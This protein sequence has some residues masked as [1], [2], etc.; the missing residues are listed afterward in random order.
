M[1]TAI[2][3]ILVLSF[4][5]FIHELGHFL[6]AKMVGIR[7]ER[8]SIGFP[9][10]MFGRKIGETDYCIS[11][12]PLGGYVKMSGMVDES[13]DATISG[14][15]WEFMSKSVFQRFLVI[16]AGPAMN[17]LLAVV[18]FAA[19]T[20]S[21]GERHPA[22]A[23]VQSVSENMPAALAGVQAGDR[24]LA[25][26][27]TPVATTT[28]VKI[29]IEQAGANTSIAMTL[30][31]GAD[32]V[33]VSAATEFNP[34]L[35]RAVLGFSM[36][37]AYEYSPVGPGA[38]LASGFAETIHLTRMIGSAFARIFDGSESARDSLA[39]PVG[40]ARMVGEVARTGMI[41]LLRFM[42]F[43]SLQ[44]ALLN[45]LPIPVLDGGHIVFLMLESIMRRPVSIRTRMVVQQIGMVFLLG[46]MVFVIFN[47]I[48][49]LFL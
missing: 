46:V 6:L 26:G 49:R 47:D 42:A 25:I 14:A 1:T 44:L 36:R 48:R 28:D 27:E 21:Q 13:M 10:R 3:F 41:P 34:E 37:Q 17:Y 18:L 12:I 29:L 22:G 45:M 15:P 2:Y 33:R 32:T 19:I 16:F 8:F 30:L 31:R 24:L 43:L 38:A 20:W 40:I 4:L 11:W 35:G 39:G 23:V 9:P 5:V 7:V